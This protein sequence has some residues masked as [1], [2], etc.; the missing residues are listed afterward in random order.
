MTST[1]R[2]QRLEC[3]EKSKEASRRNER[4]AVVV[5][6]CTGQERVR[7]QKKSAVVHEM[8]RGHIFV[9]EVPLYIVVHEVPLYIVAREVLLSIVAREMLLS[10]AARAAPSRTVVHAALSRTV[11]HAAL[12]SIVVHERLQHNLEG[13]GQRTVAHALG[14]TAAHGLGRRTALEAR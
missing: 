10:I 2:V 7:T 8:R 6:G 12:S 11:V 14:R 13:Q 5:V 3:C 9:H 4:E 1:Q